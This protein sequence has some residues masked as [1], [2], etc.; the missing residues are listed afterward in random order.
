MFFITQWFVH[1]KH[2]IN[3]NNYWLFWKIN[4]IEINTDNEYLLLLAQ[5]GV[6]ENAYH[7]YFNFEMDFTDVI[8]QVKAFLNKV[9][10]TAENNNEEEKKIISLTDK[11]FLCILKT[12]Y[13]FSLSK[14]FR[15]L[16]AYKSKMKKISKEF[17]WKIPKR[18]NFSK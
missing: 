1:V 16:D 2:Y 17:K 8:N 9:L 7:K 12:K 6:L 15:I 18:I 11:R 13:Y 14:F 3:Y 10:E 5:K 4:N